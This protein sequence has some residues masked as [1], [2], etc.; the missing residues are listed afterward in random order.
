MANDKKFIVKNQNVGGEN[1]LYMHHSMRNQVQMMLSKAKLP[2]IAGWSN[3]P[4]PDGKT[5]NKEGDWEEIWNVDPNEGHKLFSKKESE[6][7]ASKKFSKKE[8]YLKWKSDEITKQILEEKKN[9]SYLT[10][11]RR[12]IGQNGINVMGKIFENEEFLKAFSMNEIGKLMESTIHNSMHGTFNE[13]K[14]GCQYK[15]GRIS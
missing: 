6:E 7:M 9:K 1:F 14:S 15:D 8:D 12:I 2:C 5:G 3:I 11:I 4:D 13:D 10:T